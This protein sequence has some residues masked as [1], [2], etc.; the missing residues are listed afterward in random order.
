MEDGEVTTHLGLT[1]DTVPAL[2]H[3]PQGFGDN[4]WARAP[5]TPLPLLVHIYTLWLLEEL[6]SSWQGPTQQH[7][8]GQGQEGWAKETLRRKEA[9]GMGLEEGKSGGPPPRPPPRVSPVV[10][11]SPCGQEWQAGG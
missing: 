5:C 7:R 4:T 2:P 3:P 11:R 10:R 8:V 1:P 6:V 9:P